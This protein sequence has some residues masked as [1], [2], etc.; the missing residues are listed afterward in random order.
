[1]KIGIMQP[2][3]FPYLGYWQLINAVDKFVILDDVNFIKRGYINRNHILFNNRE[4]LFTLPLVKASQNKLI[5]EIGIVEDKKEIDKILLI[6]KTAYKDAP[7]FNAAYPL[8]EKIIKFKNVNLSKYITNS[9]FEICKYV[10]INTQ[11]IPSSSRY[12]KKALK[13]QLRILD[14]VE[15]ERGKTY[16]NPIGGLNLYEKGVFAKKGIKLKFI[17]MDRISYQQTNNDFVS[18]L[19]I[20]D[21]LM[22]N[23]PMEI[24]QLLDKYKLV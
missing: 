3:L 13:G 15:K 16:I 12:E 20:I 19:S 18:N 1:M 5:N 9:I 10:G 24:V 8:I 11:I 17:E 4:T 23:S 14:I 2:Y 22:F 6:I 21:I 7:Y